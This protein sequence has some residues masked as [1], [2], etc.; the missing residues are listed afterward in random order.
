MKATEANFL[1]FL[2]RSP[3]FLILSTSE[4]IAGTNGNV[5]SFGTTY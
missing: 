5:G 1:R 3:Q 2:K 4:L